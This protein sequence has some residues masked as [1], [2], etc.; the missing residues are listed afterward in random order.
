MNVVPSLPSSS[1]S[2]V[3]I[4]RDA[5]WILTFHQ[6]D[7]GGVAHDPLLELS[8]DDYYAD[9]QATLPSG[10]EGGLY[11]FV[12]EGVTDKHYGIIAQ[13]S[14]TSPSVVRLFLY[15]RDLEAPDLGILTNV[16]GA[17]FLSSGSS[18]WEK[19]FPKDLVA[20]LSI[21][22]V[23][24]RVGA[25]NY[26]AVVTARE[27]VFE[28]VSGRRPCGDQP[29][30]ATR[31]EPAIKEL[32]RRAWRFPNDGVI[33]HVFHRPSSPTFQ[34][35]SATRPVPARQ[36]ILTALI[37]LA[38]RMER[39]TGLYGRGMLLIRDGTLH[40]GP[41]LIPLEGERK[42]KPL[43]ISSGLIE[44]VALPP[45]PVDPNWDPCAKG[46][47]PRQE[48]RRVFRLTLR[49]RPD[50][51]PGDLVVFD[52]P[53]EDDV[54]TKPPLGGALGAL[55]DL[56]AAIGAA[57]GSSDMKSPLQLYV[58]SV[59]HRL[60][61]T[62]GFQTTLVGVEVQ[63]DP[64]GLQFSF[65]DKRVA[66]DVPGTTPERAPQE[67]SAEVQTAK[68]ITSFLDRAV[69]A[70]GSTEVG[71]VRAFL[72]RDDGTKPGQTETVWRGL[73]GTATANPSRVVDIKRPTEAKA[74]GVPYLT[75]FA[76][77][78]CGLILPRYPGMR[79]ALAHRHFDL[80]DPIEVG[81]L[82]QTGHAPAEA[83]PGD[84]WLILPADNPSTGNAP[85]DKQSGA[86][87]DYSGAV[88]QDLTDASGN[89][90]VEAGTMAVRVG[91][92]SL[93]SLGGGQVRP[94][95][96]D[97]NDAA[98]KSPTVFVI[99]NTRTSTRILIRDD[100]SIAIEGPNIEITARTKLTITAPTVEV[101]CDSMEVK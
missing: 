81:A 39:E 1:E 21:V 7:R 72:P 12:L 83:K 93:K 37:D 65:W 70:L 92:D 101:N 29:V 14:D 62:A 19:H 57:F 64:Q 59:E 66:A 48:M 69:R 34:D 58:R 84:W 33:P 22:S 86:P 51:K 67:A 77:G 61:R 49:G 78:K 27:R 53:P 60:A 31:L 32:M 75:P 47:K 88:T 74:D 90:L 8:R 100:G 46:A 26:E 9:I 30:D 96:A 36:P 25:R 50:L 94:A 2:D 63:G 41:R 85:G 68:A 42:A 17:D 43:T 91:V 13:N 76:W 82:W 73:E 38:A 40:F 35:D 24:R 20:E 56:G 79:V 97:A 99:E 52:P 44:P 5:G 98:G 18:K 54:N 80:N 87:Q 4:G 10:L 71:E 6:E 28:A 89:R 3:K 95:L 45:E 23:T 55:G 16:L 11:T 15:Y